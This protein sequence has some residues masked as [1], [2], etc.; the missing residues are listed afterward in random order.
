MYNREKFPKPLKNVFTKNIFCDII[1]KGAGHK[2]KQ[3]NSKKGVARLI[4]TIDI[5]N[6]NITLGGF[7][8]DRLAFAANLS[9]EPNKTADEYACAILSV[10]SVRGMTD[11]SV[12]GAIISSVVPPL[13]AVI[14]EAVQILWGIEPLTVGPGV[15]TGLNIHCDTPSSVGAD[16]ICACVAVHH[17]Y[18]VPALIIDMGTAT[19]LTVLNDKG[20]FA[21]VS[22]TPGVL[23]GL[24]S[25][26][27]NTAQLP[28][29]GLDAPK[30][31]I[32]K[33]TA[34][35]IRSGVI[36]GNA[37]MIDGMIDRISSEIG[38]NLTVYAT[39]GLAPA[40][41]PHCKHPVITDEHLVLKGLFIIYNKNR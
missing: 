1:K 3:Q 30:N 12:S 14:K 23:M 27:R 18:G 36:F 29:V 40:I 22:I 16:L 25:L 34:D 21:G 4:L 7:E 6:S 37:A 20:A 26:W 5:G 33:N 2:I 28:K 11:R 10:L 24:H 15:K 13:N 8:R 41:I 38:T 9:T 35:S 32:G 17:H 39:G 19:K 31:V